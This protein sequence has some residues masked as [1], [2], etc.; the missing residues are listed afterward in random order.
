MEYTPEQTTKIMRV[1]DKL[2]AGNDDIKKSPSTK[3][4]AINL[5]NSYGWDLE[6]TL[7]SLK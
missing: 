2:S 7:N 4:M 6:S 5:L 1:I 3:V